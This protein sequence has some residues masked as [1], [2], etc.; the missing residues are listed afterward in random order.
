ALLGILTI[1]IVLS[2]LLTLLVLLVVPAMVAGMKWITRRTG[3]LFK[4]QQ[5]DLGELNGYIE[6]A[7]S[8]GK[9]VRVFSMEQK[10]KSEFHTR[11]ARFKLSAFWAQ[12][13]SGFIPKLMNGLN[14]LNFAIIAGIGGW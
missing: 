6:E 9:I 4:D 2:P 1:M 3:K 10:V 8:G 12:V 13:I 7:L 5:R 14:N 11:N